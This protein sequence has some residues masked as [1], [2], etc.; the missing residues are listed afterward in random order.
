MLRVLSPFVLGLAVCPY[1]SPLVLPNKG[2]LL[3][4]VSFYL[5]GTR[6]SWLLRSYRLRCWSGLLAG[7]TC[8]LLGLQIGS[9][10]KRLRGSNPNQKQ[11]IETW[12]GSVLFRTLQAPTFSEGESPWANVQARI[13]THGPSPGKWVEE[14]SG[15][16][17]QKVM[18]R[19]QGID[20]LQPGS[21]LVCALALERPKAAEHPVD[22][23]QRRYLA[24]QGIFWQG[25]LDSCQYLTLE[26]GKGL[27]QAINRLRTFSLSALHRS[28]R[29]QQSAGVLAALCL[30]WKEELSQE[31]LQAFSRAGTLHILA[32]SGMHVGLVF[33]L[34]Q[35]LLSFLFLR[36]HQPT[37]TRIA[38][39]LLALAGVWTFVL[40]S[41]APPSAMRAG[42]LFSLMGLSRILHRKSAG[43]NAWA[44]T[45]FL[46]LLLQPGLLYSVG[47]Q[48][49][50][51]AVAGILWTYPWFRNKF[52]FKGWLGRQLG[53]LLA[54]SMAAQVGC[55][56][57]SWHYFG[58]FPVYF[59]LGNL[60][61]VPLVGMFLLGA[62]LLIVLPPWPITLAF[63]DLLSWLVQGWLT[64]MER[65]GNLP[66]ALL[67]L[68]HLPALATLLL[69]LSTLWYFGK[70]E[71]AR[72]SRW[73]H[74]GPAL[75]LLL[76]MGWTSW[77]GGHR[78]RGEWLVA[79]H[80][81]GQLQL[82]LVAG[83]QVLRILGQQGP[84]SEAA[85]WR[86]ATVPRFQP[87]NEFQTEDPPT[88]GHPERGLLPL[89]AGSTAIQVFSG[90]PDLGFP[91]EGFVLVLGGWPETSKKASIQSADP[92]RD[93][94]VAV[95]DA[96]AP[97]KDARLP[98]A[99]VQ[100]SLW[101]GKRPDY[102]LLSPIL[103]RRQRQTWLAWCQQQG[104]P[105]T[106]LPR[107]GSREWRLPKSEIFGFE[108]D[109][110]NLGSGDSPSLKP[111]KPLRN[112]RYPK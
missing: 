28:V 44:S 111:V 14:A 65:A 67:N 64:L 98:D 36:L 55:L 45:A 89:R 96:A 27:R 5:L 2:L 108:Q 76:V 62:A 72:G 90:A 7:I 4:T 109:S 50:F 79:S 15:L 81:A 38:E 77:R 91:E 31:D 86:A 21:L 48:L 49:S 22:F 63:A 97:V 110:A 87:A 43:K 51:S 95:Q 53:D 52:L 18:L 3:T 103:S 16:S 99:L 40:V 17:G 24:S 106:P 112:T 84:V 11:G 75:L 68:P 100:H 60:V 25:R 29:D 102:V 42:L 56:A 59:L 69:L 23:H 83:H 10:E 93:A 37:L 8:L 107:Y 47:F 101:Y 74:T 54:L 30:G 19:I 73:G 70:M 58:Q 33:L 39:S 13:L 26:Q 12:K 41:G 20:S 82:E 32:V 61:G 92:V 80:Q 71:A 88:I 85:R 66:G 34:L 94:A 105:C 6:S 78:S 35:K 57:L 104:T 46:L 9:D 1:L